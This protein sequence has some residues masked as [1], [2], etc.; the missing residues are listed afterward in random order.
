MNTTTKPQ[1]Q[2]TVTVSIA[3][4]VFRTNSYGVNA[5][6]HYDTSLMAGGTIVLS[7]FDR[8]VTPNTINKMPNSS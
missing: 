8:P 1:R 4:P 5:S 6:A 3:P 7:F 2:P